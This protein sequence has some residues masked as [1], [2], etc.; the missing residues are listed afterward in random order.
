MRFSRCGTNPR[1]ANISITARGKDTSSRTG[2]YGSCPTPL[3]RNH[4]TGSGVRTVSL[5]H[6][7][8][9]PWHQ[10]RQGP[11]GEGSAVGSA[12]RRGF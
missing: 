3:H 12:F 11:G 2:M 1:P 7:V 5:L 4:P 10:C 8:P 6:P 9:V